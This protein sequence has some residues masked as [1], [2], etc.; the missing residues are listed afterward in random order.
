MTWTKSEI[1]AGL[2]VLAANVVIAVALL[3]TWASANGIVRWPVMTP[4]HP[5]SLGPRIRHEWA[6]QDD[7]SLLRLLPGPA[8]KAP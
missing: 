4:P 5:E 2:G 8:A 3:L 7:H 1:A 6:A